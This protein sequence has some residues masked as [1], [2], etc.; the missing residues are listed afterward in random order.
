MDG[1]DQREV[2][3]AVEGASSLPL[4]LHAVHVAQA[5]EIL[6]SKHPFRVVVCLE[7]S[8]VFDLY[9]F[10]VLD[11]VVLGTPS[12]LE[13]PHPSFRHDRRDGE[14]PGQ[15]VLEDAAIDTVMLENRLDSVAI[16]RP[17]VI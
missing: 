15:S 9:L 11:L 12:R 8:I 10:D 13:G 4:R 3:K 14:I 7:P 2:I 5:E 17:K 6:T 16:H 1:S